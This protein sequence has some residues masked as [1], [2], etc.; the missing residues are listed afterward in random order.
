M[1][2]EDH[3]SMHITRSYLESLHEECDS[4]N[5]KAYLLLMAHKAVVV[6]EREKQQLEKT[7]E[8]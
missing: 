7:N 8:L 5:F 2:S 3:L 6:A 4:P 1:T